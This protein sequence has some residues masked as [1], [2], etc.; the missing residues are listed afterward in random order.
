MMEIGIFRLILKIKPGVKM[1]TKI[2]SFF[3]ATVFLFSA[4]T[5]NVTVKADQNGGAQRQLSVV[6]EGQVNVTPDIAYINIGV[7]SEADIVS[8][9]IAQNNAQAQAIKDTLLTE[10]VAE[11][12]I[13]TSTFS[14]NSQSEPGLQEGLPR[15]FF[16][17]DNSVFVTVRNLETIGNLLNAVVSSGANN[18]NGITF[19]K[20]DKSAA[21]SDARSLAVESARSQAMELANLAGVSLGE[22]ISITTSTSSPLRSPGIESAVA[23]APSVPIAQGQIQVNAMVT[24]IYAIQ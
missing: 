6:G 9:A 10:G 5:P 3:F 17:V 21:E 24:I 16:S 20:Q 11:D 22:I 12:D 23:A 2:F 14:I 18:I 19:D 7:Y 13:Q 15:I 1:S 4:C 8:D